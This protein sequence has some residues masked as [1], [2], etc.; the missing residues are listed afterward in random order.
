M[1]LLSIVPEFFGTPSQGNFLFF[2]PQYAFIPHGFWR[3]FNPPVVVLGTWSQLIALGYWVVCAIIFGL[4]AKRLP[5]GAAALIAIP[6]V[7]VA[8]LVGRSLVGA[9]GLTI[10]LDGP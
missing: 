7:V 1:P 8:L 10:V 9:L 2:W 6:V 3:S 5:A 4:L